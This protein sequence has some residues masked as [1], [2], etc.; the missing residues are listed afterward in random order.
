MN[1][2][3]RTTIEALAA[4]Q[5]GTQSLHTNSFDEAVGLPTTQTARIARNTQLILQEETGMCDVADPWAGSFMMES[6]T[7]D[8]VDEAMRI[9]AEVDEAGGMTNYIQSGRAKLRIEESATKRQ[10]RIDSSEETIVGVNKYQS[11]KDEQEIQDV[12]D[13]DNED[14]RVKQ[15]ARLDQV[16]RERDASRVERALQKITDSAR[17][18]GSKGNSNDPDNLLALC[19][20][21]ARE[22]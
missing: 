21:A 12:L 11:E 20:E 7:N 3:V 16:K 17:R 9:L 5:G 10:A 14:V 19:L 13:I 6:M 18:K 2:I 4:V 8:L 15:I 22:R 1:N